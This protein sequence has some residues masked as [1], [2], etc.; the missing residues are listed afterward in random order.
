MITVRIPNNVAYAALLAGGYTVRSIDPT[1]YTFETDAPLEAGQPF[2]SGGTRLMLTEG[3]LVFPTQA[4]PEN[5]IATLDVMIKQARIKAMSDF[6]N[7][8]VQNLGQADLG[9]GD[10]KRSEGA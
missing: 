9:L 8:C 7:E 2:S 1:T 5:G 3:G 4:Q 10:S 6:E